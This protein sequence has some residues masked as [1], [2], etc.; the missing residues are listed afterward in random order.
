MDYNFIKEILIDESDIQK[1]EKYEI[2]CMKDKSLSVETLKDD[3]SSFTNSDV[4][5]VCYRCVVGEHMGYASTELISESE[6]RFLV[7][8]AMENAMNIENNDEPFI[9]NRIRRPNRNY[10]S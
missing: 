9:N 3:I 8:R 5:G 1:V 7:S 4:G 6:L 10:F 2:Y